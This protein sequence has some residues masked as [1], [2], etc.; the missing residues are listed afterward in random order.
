V[1]GFGTAH[2]IARNSGRSIPGK[3]GFVVWFFKQSLTFNFYPIKLLLLKSKVPNI[4]IVKFKKCQ[5]TLKKT[6]VKTM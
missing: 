5:A 1:I 4:D 6:F 3:G 2:V